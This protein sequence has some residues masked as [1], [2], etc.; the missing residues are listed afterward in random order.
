MEKCEKYAWT[1]S[2]G[3][4]SDHTLDSDGMSV[5]GKVPFR[6]TEVAASLEGRRRVN[7]F[8]LSTGG[9]IK[10]TP[11]R[12]Y[13]CREDG[14]LVIANDTHPFRR[15]H[16]FVL[17]KEGRF[18]HSTLFTS[19]GGQHHRMDIVTTET[20][21]YI[22]APLKVWLCN[23]HAPEQE[24][25]EW[26]NPGWVMPFVTLFAGKPCG[27]NPFTEWGICRDVDLP[28]ELAHYARNF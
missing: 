23:L 22:G 13:C 27:L 18:D 25:P 6:C 24:I 15:N 28:I 21:T 1:V 5:P 11:H 8:M 10:H 12:F 3:N 20:H 19:L 2:L 17:R 7:L 14:T 9:D 4:V 26:D 16:G